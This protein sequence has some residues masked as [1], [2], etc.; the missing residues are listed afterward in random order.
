MDF[1]KTLQDAAAVIEQY[2]LKSVI[3]VDTSFGEV[4]KVLVI[5]LNDNTEMMQFNDVVSVEREGD[6]EYPTEL[7]T[8]VDGIRLLCLVDEE[9]K[10]A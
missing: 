4:G 5:H 2:Q 8:M 10:T 6:K 3:S 1:A 9:E 7:V